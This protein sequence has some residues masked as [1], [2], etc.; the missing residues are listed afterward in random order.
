MYNEYVIEMTTATTL[1][2]SDARG[3]MLVPE[4]NFMNEDNV[5]GLWD[6]YSYYTDKWC[7][8]VYQDLDTLDVEASGTAYNARS[9]GILQTAWLGF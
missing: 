6:T 4:P 9:Y 2:A 7:I 8:H 3:R 5:P 1:S